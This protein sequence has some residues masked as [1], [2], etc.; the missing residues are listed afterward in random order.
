MDVVIAVIASVL[1]VLAL[2][3]M[4]AKYVMGEQSKMAQNYEYMLRELESRAAQMSRKDREIQQL[5]RENHRLRALLGKEE[6]ASSDTV[7]EE[8]DIEE[9]AEPEAGEDTPPPSPPK[10][11]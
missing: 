2:V 8:M 4:L 10:S 3:A 9:P 11:G 7:V 5:R 6:K 1:V